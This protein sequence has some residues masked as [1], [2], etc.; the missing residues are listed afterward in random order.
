MPWTEARQEVHLG[1]LWAP[2]RPTESPVAGSAPT[3]VRLSTYAGR[4][5]PLGSCRF[6]PA[7]HRLSNALP[8]RVRP[9][10][11]RARLVGLPAGGNPGPHHAAALPSRRARRA[12]RA[13]PVRGGEPAGDHGE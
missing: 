9:G 6:R 1:E 12:G 10:R 13:G 3:D 7:A 11:T 2:S 5:I 8:V 4:P